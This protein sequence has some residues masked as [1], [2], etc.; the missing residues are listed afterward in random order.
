MNRFKDKCDVCHT[1][2]YCSG[3]KKRVVCD[4]CKMIIDKT[5]VFNDEQYIQLVINDDGEV[6]ENEK[7]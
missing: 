5:I 3:Y 6:V 2:Q 4:K 7:N 1:Y